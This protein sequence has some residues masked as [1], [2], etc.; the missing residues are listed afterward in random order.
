METYTEITDGQLAPGAP[1]TVSLATALARNP[2]AIAEGASGA[3]FIHMKAFQKLT[4]GDELRYVDSNSGY[5]VI[6]ENLSTVW[7][8]RPWQ[9]GTVRIT[10]TLSRS[11]TSAV[12]NIQSNGVTVWDGSTRST[13]TFSVDLDV[14]PGHLIRIRLRV[15]SDGPSKWARLS[16]VKLS[17][18]GELIL[19]T[20]AQNDWIFP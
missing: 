9:E 5:R 4:A 11:S 18:N 12:A 2:Q 7:S 19:P 3:P 15:G 20:F 10:F 14:T 8:W 1:I 6:N 17:T 13:Q 16:A